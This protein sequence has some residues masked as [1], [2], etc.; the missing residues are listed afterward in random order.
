MKNNKLIFTL[1]IGLTLL[2]F[3]C[4]DDENQNIPYSPE[5]SDE[6]TMTITEIV[7]NDSRTD[8]LM[9]ALDKADLATTFISPGTFTLFAPTNDA[10]IKLIASDSTWNSI[11]DIDNNSLRDLILYHTIPSVAQF[12]S[13]TNDTYHTTLNTQGTSNGEATVIEFDVSNGIV[14]NNHSTITQAEILATNGIVHLIDD[15]IMPRNTAELLENDE[16]FS[17]LGSALQIVGDTITNLISGNSRHTIFAP[18]NEAFQFLLDSEST[19][20]SISDIPLSRLDSIL[21]YHIVTSDNFQAS[22]LESGK[23]ITTASGETITIDSIPN[24]I[25]TIDTSQSI[26]K[27]IDTDIQGTNGVVHAIDEILLP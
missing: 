18:T 5:S 13:I 1:F 24:Q 3:S 10:F 4:G 11:A 22:Q 15:V 17:S 8:S 16:R 2:I 6:A 9:V 21:R 20:I 7:S 25:I 14:L 26:V 12:S 23:L 19:W 27:I